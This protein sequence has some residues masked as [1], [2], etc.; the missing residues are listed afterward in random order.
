ME[1]IQ[2]RTTPYRVG[3]KYGEAICARCGRA[4]TNHHNRHDE[5]KDCLLVTGYYQQARRKNRDDL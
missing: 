4:F 5:C 3:R 2:G 1:P